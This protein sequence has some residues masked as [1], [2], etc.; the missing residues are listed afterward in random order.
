MMFQLAFKISW[1]SVILS[2]LVG[3][4]MACRGFGIWALVFQQLVSAVVSCCMYWFLVKWH[5]VLKFSWVKLKGLFAFGWKML[6]SAL[7]EKIFSNLS[8]FVIGKFFSLE[9]LGF[10]NRGKS[11][12]EL[13]MEIFN[14]SLY[15]VLLPYYSKMQQDISQLRQKCQAILRTVIFITAPLVVLMI[16]FA[17]PFVEIVFSKKWLPCVP[18]LQLSALA[19]LLMPAQIV[20]LQLICACGRSDIFLLLEIIKKVQM[21]AMLG[22]TIRYGIIAM[23]WGLV[24][25]SFISFIENSW[26]NTKLINY[27]PWR[28]LFDMLPEI[29]ISFLI[30]FVVY[31]G[32]RF[33][34]NNWLKLILG[35]LLF[36]F[37]YVVVMFVLKRIPQSIAVVFCNSFKIGISPER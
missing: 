12:P 21:L 5:P 14:T 26:F 13:G 20:N 29:F 19:Y 6:L 11:V 10:Y 27:P 30:G 35:G 24:I 15:T 1:C 7:L 36:F 34:D 22:L 37:I 18:Y 2:G 17:E 8:S 9:M 23:V 4:Y 32:A 16:V 25:L 31:H 28:Q 3:V 33:V